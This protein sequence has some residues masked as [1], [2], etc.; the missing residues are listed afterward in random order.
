MDDKSARRQK[1]HETLINI[2]NVSKRLY[3]KLARE[4]TSLQGVSARTRLDKIV[5]ASGSI[6]EKSLGNDTS[7]DPRL[8]D[9][10]CSKEPDMC[11]LI[12][13]SMEKS[14]T[15]DL[16][17]RTL[18]GGFGSAVTGNSMYAEGK[19]KE[20][21]KLFDDGQDFFHFLLAPEVWNRETDIRSQPGV[22]PGSV[23][24]VTHTIALARSR[25]MG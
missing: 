17:G 4:N 10:L 19:T 20:A 3:T 9:W 2:E 21:I 22:V 5:V 25:K 24:R 7:L 18:W 16:G 14:I 11:L 15:A 8:E 13:N 6:L 23:P 12:L 1:A